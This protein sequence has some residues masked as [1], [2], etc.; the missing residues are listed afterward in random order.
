MKKTLI[1]AILLFLML[2]NC[3][4]AQITTEEQ[5]M[6]LQ[7]KHS[8][9]LKGIRNYTRIGNIVNLPTPNLKKL[10]EEDSISEKRGRKSY[11]ISAK[12][13]VKIDLFSSGEWTIL[14]DG[15][16]L[17]HLTFAVDDAQSLD[18]TFSKFWLPDSTKFFVYNPLTLE[19]IGAI[20]SEYIEGDSINPAKFSTAMIEGD[21]ITLEY[22]QPRDIVGNPVVEVSGV[23][24]GYRTKA[25]FN[26]DRYGLSGECQVNVNCQ[27]GNN[28]SDEKRAVARLYLKGEDG[29]CWCTGSLVMNTS[30]DFTPYLLTA[31]HCAAAVGQ[32]VDTN[33]D[34]TESIFYWNYETSGCDSPQNYNPTWKSTVGATLIANN[35]YS[36]FALYRLIQNPRLLNGYSP[37]YLGWDRSEY[38]T[39]GGVCIHHP[40]GDVKKI[41]TYTATPLATN[42]LGNNYL[43]NGTHWRVTWIETENGHATTEPG[44]SGSALLNSAHRLIGQLHGGSSSCANQTA[45]DWYGRLFSSWD[46]SS[47]PNRR[48]HDWLD[49]NDTGQLT[50]DG[51]NYFSM[52]IVGQSVPCGPEIYY[53]SN[54]PVGY[55]VIWHFYNT[56]SPLSNLILQNTP[57]YNMCT[58]NLSAGQD[59]TEILKADIIVNTHT[60][61]SISRSVYNTHPVGGAYSQDA[62]ATTPAINVT[63]FSGGQPISVYKNA[64]ATIYSGA[65]TNKSVTYTGSSLAYWNYDPSGIVRFMFPESEGIQSILISAQNLDSCEKFTIGAITNEVE[66]QDNSEFIFSMNS[67]RLNIIRRNKVP[68][69]TGSP[70]KVSI[71]NSSNGNTVYS[72]DV[73]GNCLDVPISGWQTGIYVVTLDNGINIKSYKVTIK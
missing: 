54:L 67:N 33:T 69:N 30:L 16:R 7:L 61:T 17:C 10:L 48:L 32:D 49:P 45:P 52:N 13:P 56:S 47:L 19:T 65:L 35:A 29:G 44:S 15:S 25:S 31:N 20:T 11:R 21:R 9:Q 22:Y 4:Y 66:S 63:A 50:I 58:L 43:S 28:W 12:I 5:P 6:S 3:S 73:K 62:G 41:S 60:A 34:A 55:D 72:G 1:L 59:I 24:Y 18:L 40:R 8:S 42:Y 37:Y 68:T 14:D 26:P 53:V 23:Y 2:N 38:P 36:D 71:L 46:C 51:Q 57:D 64:V 39:S 27:E 70:Y